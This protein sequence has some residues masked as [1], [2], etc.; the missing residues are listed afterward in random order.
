[1]TVRLFL[2][3]LAAATGEQDSGRTLL[4]HGLTNHE[5]IGLSS[6]KL[7]LP[8]SQYLGHIQENAFA[9]LPSASIPQ[10]VSGSGP[11]AVT[12]APDPSTAT[13]GITSATMEQP[14][15]NAATTNQRHISSAS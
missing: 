8:I 1:M 6:P 12:I 5:K 4:V 15:A 14:P 11:Q 2:L 7:S 10:R 9:P 3:S 13:A